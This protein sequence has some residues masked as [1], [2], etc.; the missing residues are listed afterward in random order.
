MQK[1]DAKDLRIL[2]ALQRDS[3]AAVTDLA[4]QLGCR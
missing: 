4:A 1:Y 3:T 2:R